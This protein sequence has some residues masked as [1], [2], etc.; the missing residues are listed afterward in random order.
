MEVVDHH[1]YDLKYLAAEDF[2]YNPAL[3]TGQLQVRDIHYVTLTKRSASEFCSLLDAKY[4]NSEK[5]GFE[6]WMKLAQ[7][8]GW[9]KADE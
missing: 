4:L 6:E 8:N 3:G 1:A 9:I 5:K 2:S 7:K